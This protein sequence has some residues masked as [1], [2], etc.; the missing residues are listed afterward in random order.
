MKNE[1]LTL[2]TKRAVFEKINALLAKDP[3][4]KYFVN[5]TAKAK[6]EKLTSK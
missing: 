5:I 6:K 3:S 2:N 1:T 4:K